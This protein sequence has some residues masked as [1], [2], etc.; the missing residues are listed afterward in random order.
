[1]RNAVSVD[2]AA[3]AALPTGRPWQLFPTI[4]RHQRFGE[5]IDEIG[6]RA[7]LSLLNGFA[8]S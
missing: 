6:A 1:V 7:N 3:I 5:P 2:G 8:I 4:W